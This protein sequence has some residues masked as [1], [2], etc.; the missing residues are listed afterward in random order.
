MSS[1]VFKGSFV[2]FSFENTR[3]IDTNEL[4]AKRMEEHSSVLRERSKNVPSEPEIE[5]D[6]DGNPIERLTEDYEGYNDEYGDLSQESGFSEG[7]IVSQNEPMPISR[8]EII[9]ECQ[10]LIDNAQ[11]E[12]DTILE[13]ARIAAE[14]IRKN[15]GDLGYQEGLENGRN[16]GLQEFIVQKALLDTEKEELSK[17]YETLIAEFE[18]KLVNTIVSVYEHI[19]GEGLY[20]KREVM[21]T[22]IKRAFSETD[23][24]DQ[25]IVHVSEDDYDLIFDR[26]DALVEAKGYTHTPELRRHS[27]LQKGQ[28]K[29]ETNYGIIDCSIDTELAELNK[30]LRALAFE[31]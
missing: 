23:V 10:E 28:C 20:D 27:D 18:P 24:D 31:K 9:A 14:E 12:A 6:E 4:V 21:L 16:E 7:G 25:V 15:A 11:A 22:L 26:F 29:I 30:T 5:Y 2:Q 1:N 3:V 8:D 17:K 13:N 19:F